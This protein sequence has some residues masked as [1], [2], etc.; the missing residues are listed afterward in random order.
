[1][2]LG[3]LLFALFVTVLLGVF[4]YKKQPNTLYLVGLFLAALLYSGS[5]FFI[6]S[7]RSVTLSV[8]FINHFT[9]IYL[10]AG[11][12]MYFYVRN[13]LQGRGGLAKKDFF[14]FL[15]AVLQL[16]AILPY[17]F[18]S[19]AYKQ[20][21]IQRILAD[22][23]Y[24]NEANFNIFFGANLNF[25]I[26]LLLL[27]VYLLFSIRILILF[28][29]EQQT[30]KYKAT[31]SWLS[32]LLASIFLLLVS[33]SMFVLNIFSDPSSLYST[34][35]N[36]LLTIAGFSFC[37]FAGIP[38]LYPHVLY[39][40][41]SPSKKKKPFELPY[42]GEELPT[43]YYLNMAREIDELF[44]KK[45]PYLERVFA[46]KELASVLGVPKHHVHHCF[47][48]VF[49]TTFTAYKTKYRIA[50]VI[51]ALDH[52][53]F[54]NDTIDGIGSA[55]GFNSKS[56]FYTIFKRETGYSPKDYRE[57]VLRG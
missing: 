14:H 13:T 1:M 24:M 23:A 31:I 33:Y 49:N 57:Q 32:Y 27:L 2:F 45:A 44:E 26:R 10:M 55:A 9:P 40:A 53:D 6:S 35:N 20:N 12:F 7:L 41:K 36:I 22:P 3:I 29:K 4:N 15:P 48:S 56:H 50:W 42:G 5:H 34:T 43:N 52:H 46:M 47:K 30:K 39:G 28:K 16:V 8:I 51:E 54:R 21:I 38:L 17:S 18:S 11:P 37:L 19:W 25:G